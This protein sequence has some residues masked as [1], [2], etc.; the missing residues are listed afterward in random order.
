MAAAVSPVIPGAA[1]FSEHMPLMRDGGTGGAFSAHRPGIEELLRTW[2]EKHQ[3]QLQEHQ[4]EVAALLDGHL[5]E[6]HEHHSQSVAA[7]LDNHL[8]D[9]LGASAVACGGAAGDGSA[10]TKPTV[11]IASDSEGSV[12]NTGLPCPNRTLT[13]QKSAVSESMADMVETH[14]LI[15]DIGQKQSQQ[16]KMFHQDHIKQTEHIWHKLPSNTFTAIAREVHT[17]LINI[18]EPERSG[19]IY[20]LVYARSFEALCTLIITLNSVF[21]GYRADFD[22]ENPGE[23]L[24]PFIVSVE[25]ALL[26][27][28][29]V[30]VLMKIFVHRFHFFTNCAWKWNVFDFSLVMMSAYDQL[31]SLADPASSGSSVTFMRMFRIIKLSKVM[32]IFRVIKVLRELRMMLLALAGSMMSLFWAVLML[33][34]LLYVFGLMFMQGFSDMFTDGSDAPDDRKEELMSAFGSMILTMT[35]LYMAGTGG[36]DWSYYYKMVQ[37]AGSGYGV[38]FLFY[39]AFFTFAVMNILTGMIVDNIMTIGSDDEDVVAMAFRRKNYL[40]VESARK[41]FASLDADSSGKISKAEFENAIDTAEVLALLDI[42]EL[43]ARDA[44][45]FFAMLLAAC[46]PSC[47]QGVEPGVDIDMFVDGCMKMKGSATSIELQCLSFSMKLMQETCLHMQMDVMELKEMATASQ[48]SKQC[49][50]APCRLPSPETLIS[51][52]PAGNFESSAL[53]FEFDDQVGKLGLEILWH[54]GHP[55]AGK[56][57]AMGAAQIQGVEPGDMFTE[58]NG[59]AVKGLPREEVLASLKVRPLRLGVRRCH[60]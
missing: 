12:R 55:L 34:F 28:Y 59:I 57:E 58:C 14:G 23:K 18:E 54:K 39:I 60:R 2:A 13:T 7:L 11:R 36:D 3:A 24:T 37:L 38:L 27:F 5:Q 17:F 25:W 41:L 52:Q 48:P 53:H 6:R 1:S 9:V 16:S 20:D 47:A 10:G 56:I 46:E 29:T 50:V 22:V 31:S 8:R 4:A 33:I 49:S 40:A 26:V 19:F 51:K 43:D 44:R 32:R 45:L 35:T 15:V 42:V 21:A 30:E